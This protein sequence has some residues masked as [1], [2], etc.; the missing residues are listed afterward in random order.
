MI[1][2]LLSV[3]IDRQ[4]SPKHVLTALTLLHSAL[5]LTDPDSNELLASPSIELIPDKKASVVKPKPSY[6]VIKVLLNKLGEL[7]LPCN[8]SGNSHTVDLKKQ[9][10][11]TVCGISVFS[12]Y[13]HNRGD[14]APH[15]I[16]Q[17]VLRFVVIE[18]VVRLHWI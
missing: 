9:H 12:V 18:C 10:R 8:H 13:V 16:V 17:K 1:K 15:E 11:S 14:I 3:V 5:P 4:A 7:L 6:S 2:I